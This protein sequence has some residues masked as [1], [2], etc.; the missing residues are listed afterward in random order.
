MY[1]QDIKKIKSWILSTKLGSKNQPGGRP[2]PAVYRT[3]LYCVRSHY[4]GRLHMAV[5]NKDHKDILKLFDPTA[6]QQHIADPLSGK[7]EFKT[8]DDQRAFIIHMIHYI[9]ATRTRA[10][11][12]LA[13]G[14][15]WSWLTD[16]AGLETNFDKVVD[17]GTEVAITQ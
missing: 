2:S 13:K 6:G 10:E 8:L 9:I 12:Y 16:W 15:Q 4:R 17:D 1:K 3:F 7:V 11:E 14:C 5:W